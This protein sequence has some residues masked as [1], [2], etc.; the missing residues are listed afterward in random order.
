MSTAQIMQAKH[1]IFSELP[2]FNLLAKILYIRV[3][4]PKVVEREQFEW[5]DFFGAQHVRNVP[6]G[7]IFAYITFAAF[8]KRLLIEQKF[9]FVHI[10]AAFARKGDAMTSVV[11]LHNAI[12]SI[13]ARFNNWNNIV[14]MADAQ[15]MH[16][17][18]TR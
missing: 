3:E 11:R 2:L 5:R 13:D 16:G 18:S 17:L 10:Q 1:G 14:G 6:A 9:R 12:K 4:I 15:K 7:I 8:T